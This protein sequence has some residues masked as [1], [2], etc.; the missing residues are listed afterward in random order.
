[1]QLSNTVSTVVVHVTDVFA[2]FPQP[3]LLPPE[4]SGTDFKVTWTAVSN[5]IY[6]VEFNPNLFPSNWTAL[7]GD[8]TA[9]SNTA[10]KLD[11][12]TASNRLYRVRVLS[13]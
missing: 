12:L 13:P 8:V 4:I 7:P 1:M 2:E 5:M 3:L 9:I 10:S 11:P 6:R